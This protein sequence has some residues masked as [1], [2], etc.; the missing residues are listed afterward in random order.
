MTEEYDRELEKLRWT[1]LA[2]WALSGFVAGCLAY[3]LTMRVWFAVL[4]AFV[5]FILLV[6]WT[7]RSGRHG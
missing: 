2:V 4:V 5:V 6:I 7:D 1:I 3:A